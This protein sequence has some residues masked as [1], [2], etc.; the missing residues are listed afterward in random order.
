M[1]ETNKLALAFIVLLLGWLATIIAVAVIWLVFA[2]GWLIPLTL[3]G[4]FSLSFVV[5]IA[6]RV[7]LDV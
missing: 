7:K 4:G 3:I 6:M 2:E 5:Y 1:T